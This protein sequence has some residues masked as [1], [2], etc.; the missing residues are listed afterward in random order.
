MC[1]SLFFLYQS[2]RSLLHIVA[3][4][5]PLTL[6]YLSPPNP[7]PSVCNMSI[8]EHQVKAL[9]EVGVKK[10]VLAVSYKAED[11]MASLA[12]YE[13]KYNI[14]VVCSLEEVPM[15]TGECILSLHMRYAYY[16]YLYIIYDKVLCL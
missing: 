7:I 8:L 11:M 16:I 12:M 14:T 13:K 9:V 6:S 2:L 15:G 3:A 4:F 1:V 5:L 10:I